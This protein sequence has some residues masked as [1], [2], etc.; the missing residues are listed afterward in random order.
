[1]ETVTQESIDNAVK[2]YFDQQN[3][4]NGEV[5]KAAVVGGLLFVGAFVTAKTIARGLVAGYELRKASKEL[6][7]SERS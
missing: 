2:T 7:K 3:P 5:V 1:M 4:S 6:K